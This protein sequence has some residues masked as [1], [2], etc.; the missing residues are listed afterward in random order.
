MNDDL[1]QAYQRV[2]RDLKDR[3][4]ADL[5]SDGRRFTTAH[6]VNCS[7]A[8]DGLQ[9]VFQ[10]HTFTSYVFPSDSTSSSQESSNS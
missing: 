6:G 7:M 1:Y 8:Y 5:T 4:I 9:R 2:I 3:I 10:H